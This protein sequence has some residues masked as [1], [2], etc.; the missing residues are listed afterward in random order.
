MSKQE[1]KDGKGLRGAI[2]FQ[3]ELAQKALSIIRWESFVAKLD[4]DELT[5]KAIRIRYPEFPGGE[6]FL[7]ITA[8][9]ADKPCVAFSVGQGVLDVILVLA[10]R[11]MN[12]SLKWKEDQYAK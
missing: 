5:I 4:E 8:D 10:H 7:V 12:G 11:Q 2:A 6:Y 3:E 1:H 9:V